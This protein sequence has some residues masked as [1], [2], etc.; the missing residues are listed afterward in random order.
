[1]AGRPVTPLDRQ[2]SE[3]VRALRA[4]LGRSSQP[5]DA[6]EDQVALDVKAVPDP[7]LAPRPDYPRK[8]LVRGWEGTVIL[9]VDVARDGRPTR[10]LLLESS[11]HEVLDAAALSAAQ[12]WRFRPARRGTQAVDSTVRVPVEFRIVDR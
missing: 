11:G 8:A 3:E 6:V 10:V 7:A 2:K 9:G 1:M 5:G 4:Q 12:A